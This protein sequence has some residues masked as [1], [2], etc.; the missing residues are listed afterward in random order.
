MLV[1]PANHQ[2]TG[3]ELPSREYTFGLR[4]PKGQGGLGGGGR[5]TQDI[6][7]GGCVS[8]V[9]LV[10]ASLGKDSVVGGG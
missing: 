9:L 4:V 1:Q 7:E 2:A 10:L 6:G 3:V 8:R 5:G